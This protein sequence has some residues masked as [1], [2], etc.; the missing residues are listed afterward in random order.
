MTAVV[1]SA[2]RV[3]RASSESARAQCRNL[4][5]SVFDGGTILSSPFP[6]TTN[7]RPGS[8]SSCA[9]GIVGLAIEA[10]LR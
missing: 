8:A 2:A 4:R 7:R 6:S 10:V 5:N 9:Y 3:R 1:K